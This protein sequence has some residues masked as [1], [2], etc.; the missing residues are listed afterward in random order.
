MQQDFHGGLEWKA[1][2]V[3]IHETTVANESDLTEWC[4]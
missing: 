2:I 3:S 4:R 1:R